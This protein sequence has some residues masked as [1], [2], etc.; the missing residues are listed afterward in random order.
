MGYYIKYILTTAQGGLVHVVAECLWR[1]E[2]YRQTGQKI[3]MA[4]IFLFFFYLNQLIQ[5]ELNNH[6]VTSAAVI[7]N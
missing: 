2:F 7:E 1:W 6:S 3:E 4:T 5:E